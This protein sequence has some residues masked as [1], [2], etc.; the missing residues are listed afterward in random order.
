MTGECAMSCV[1]RS[2]S[3]VTEVDVPEYV[4]LRRK[5]NLIYYFPYT[6]L[7]IY[8]WVS[9]IVS[10]KIYLFGCEPWSCVPSINSDSRIRIRY[11]I[12]WINNFPSDNV[13]RITANGDKA[14]IEGSCVP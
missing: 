13:A 1:H 2:V 14:M 6:F 7:E 8:A 11:C 9:R 4:C 10:L 12:N 3:A 5:M